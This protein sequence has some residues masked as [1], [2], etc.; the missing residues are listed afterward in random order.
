[1]Q[2]STREV[3]FVE[4][5][6]WL[7]QC[8]LARLCNCFRPSVSSS[9]AGSSFPS[10]FSPESPCTCHHSSHLSVSETPPQCIGRYSWTAV[11]G[12]FRILVF[13][14]FDITNWIFPDLLNDPKFI[15][16]SIDFSAQELICNFQRSKPEHVSID[17]SST[18]CCSFLAASNSDCCWFMAA[19]I[20]CCLHAHFT[21]CQ[22]RQTD[23][24]A[25][26]LHMASLTALFEAKVQRPQPL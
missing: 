3:S 22:I 23:F 19:S 7:V 9:V 12:V 18:C 2:F 26:L 8:L 21:L 14:K 24:F 4:L 13:F 10:G 17:L 15:Y 25:Q 11:S 20:C 5:S 6:N 16:P 1:M